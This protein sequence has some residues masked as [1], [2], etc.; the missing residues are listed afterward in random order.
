MT[1]YLRLIRIFTGATISAQLEYRAN[2]IGAVLSSLGQVGVALLAIGVLFGQGSDT[3]GG[4]TFREALLVTG[5]FILTEGFIAVF[6][7]P[8]MSRIAD[9]IRTGS[10]DF[11]LL[12]PVDAQFSVS[13][14]YLNVLRV[15]DIL[16]G[17]GLIVYAA[18]GLTTTL[19][20]VLIAAVLY[21]SALTIVYCIWLALSTTAFWFVKTQNVAELFNG[22]FGA[23]RFPVTAFPLPVRFALT[24]IVPIALITT[25]PAQAM[26]GRLSPA[27]AMASPLVAAGLFAVT[28]LFWLRA[29]ASYTSASS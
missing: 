8:S 25:V 3:V 14:R 2:F 29:V 17:L 4:W 10:M 12:K 15:P 9:A 22:I 16:I 27:L 26:T 21:A 11:T 13:T 28:R 7:Q 20:G 5:F 1:R 6:I 24:F 19:G 18:S 23:G